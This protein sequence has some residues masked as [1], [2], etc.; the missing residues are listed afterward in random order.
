MIDKALVDAIANAAAEAGQPESVASR[1]TAWLREMSET[2]M[3]REDNERF[4]RDV[5]RALVMEEDDEN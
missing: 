1:L 3:A 5:C 2:D 4:L